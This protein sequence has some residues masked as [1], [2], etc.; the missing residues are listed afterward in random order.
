MSLTFTTSEAP[1]TNCLPLSAIAEYQTLNKKTTLQDK[2]H[3]CDKTTHKQKSSKM[4]GQDLTSNE[5]DCKPFYNDLCRDISSH[6]LSHTEIDLLDSGSNSSS[7]CSNKM[8]EKS[9]FSTNLKYHHNKNS[10]KTCLQYFMSSHAGCM[11]SEDTKLKSRKIRIYP[12]QQQKHLFKQWFGISRKFYNEAVN[13]Y[14]DENKT[15]INWMEVAKQLI[16]SLTE[17]YV[18]EVPYQ[19][20]KIAVSN[21]TKQ[22]YQT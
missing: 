6:L 15:I 17:D 4:S 1:M 21:L 9:W 16:H 19:I 12:T 8:V 10:Q 22:R 18:K 13:H 20:K 3:L 5:K 11:V 7:S 14:N 2:S